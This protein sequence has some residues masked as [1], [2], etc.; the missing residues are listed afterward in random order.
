MTSRSMLV[1]WEG[2]GNRLEFRW[3]LGPPLEHPKS[4]EPGQVRVKHLS[5][6]PTSYQPIISWPYQLSAYHQLADPQ[7]AN[8]SNQDWIS[9]IPNLASQPCA[10][11]KG[12]PADIYI[13]I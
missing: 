6:G 13:Y 11:H 1:V 3:I 12:G 10:S 2:P 9:G 5:G 4:R 8:S 7:T